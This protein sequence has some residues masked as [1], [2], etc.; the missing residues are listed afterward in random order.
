MTAITGGAIALV[1]LIVLL[2]LEVPVASALLATAVV[3]LWL[4]G[5]LQLALIGQAA[6]DSLDSIELLSLPLFVLMGE[7][8]A[9]SKISSRLFEA[10]DRWFKAIPAHLAVAT[11]ATSA[12]FSALCGSSTATAAA[13]GTMSIPEMKKRGYPGGFAA[14][15]VVAGGTLGILIPPSVT[16]IIYGVASGESI[17]KLF[18]AGVIP[19]LLLSGLFAAWAMVYA[20]WAR[21][22]DNWKSAD[23]GSVVRNARISNLKLVWYVVP[24]V[25]LILGILI[26]LY[27]GVV[28]PSEVG[29][30][31]AFGAAIIALC[32]RDLTVRKIGKTFE[33]A[34]LDSAMIM[35]IVVGAALLLYPLSFLRVPQVIAEA[36]AASGL[37]PWGIMILINIMLLVLGMFLPPVAIILII[38]PIILPIVRQNGFDVLWFGVLMTINMELGMI[39]PPVGG[40]L[41]VVQGIAP[42][43]PMEKI[44]IHSIGYV[45][46]ILLTMVLISVFPEIVTW[47]PSM[48]SN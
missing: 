39:T 36:V 9:H 42:D 26:L 40:N 16:L 12:L 27:G 48:M 7:I 10:L 17:G 28:S 35:L 25:A 11:V 5:P 20:L 22:A 23:S 31:A 32:F 2:A 19:G 1:G 4:L 3:L 6:Y 18:M 33:R 21:G 43:I 15:T 24:P 41:F 47:L 37:S 29:A 14:A 46:M 38:T 30:I 34:A 13:V 45:A 8:F 44:L